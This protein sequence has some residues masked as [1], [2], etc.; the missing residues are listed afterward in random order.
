MSPMDITSRTSSIAVH[1]SGIPRQ[2]G[3]MVVAFRPDWLPVV[4]VFRGEF[5]K[6]ER[7]AVGNYAFIIHDLSLCDPDFDVTEDTWKQ[8]TPIER[9]WRFPHRPHDISSYRTGPSLS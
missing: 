3:M 4:I 9:G 7:A 8:L 5:N 6:K 1:L 2:Q